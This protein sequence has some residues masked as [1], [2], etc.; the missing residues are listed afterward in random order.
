MVGNKNGY[1]DG[2]STTVLLYP[3]TVQ[4]RERIAGVGHVMK[5][6]SGN[7]WQ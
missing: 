4:Q 1:Y 3:T 2:T 6:V 5:N 7:N